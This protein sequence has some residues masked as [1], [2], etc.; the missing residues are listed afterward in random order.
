[1]ELKDIKTV[2]EPLV[3]KYKLP[4]FKKLNEEFEVE[5]LEKEKIGEGKH[6]EYHKLLHELKNI[7]L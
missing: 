1:M 3:K 6:E 7:Y 2:Y 5:K 4:E